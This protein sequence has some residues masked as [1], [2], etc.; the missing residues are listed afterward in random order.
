MHLKPDSDAYYSFLKSAELSGI[1][2]QE[3]Y[4]G[5]IYMSAYR[6]KQQNGSNIACPGEPSRYLDVGW[7]YV[8]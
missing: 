4:S 7:N 5:S 2:V 3:A 8:D 1:A 6:A